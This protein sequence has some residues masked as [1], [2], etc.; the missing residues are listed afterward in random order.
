MRMLTCTC[1]LVV[2]LHLTSAL[3]A[4]APAGVQFDFGYLEP[5]AQLKV[6]CWADLLSAQLSSLTPNW[7][8]PQLVH[9]RAFSGNAIQHMMWAEQR[10]LDD[11]HEG[12]KALMQK[13]QQLVL[14][15]SDNTKQPRQQQHS[16]LTSFSNFWTVDSSSKPMLLNSF[17]RKLSM[18]LGSTSNLQQH[19]DQA[20]GSDSSFHP[21][22]SSIAG[23]WA[24]TA[25]PSHTNID[26]YQARIT[27]PG[28]T[29]IEGYLA[30]VAPP[31]H[32]SIEGYL[33]K[34]A[35]PSHTSINGYLRKLPDI[36]RQPSSGMP[37]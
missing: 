10:L 34:N 5:Q 35:P 28:H 15:S 11:M 7:Q 16:L 36:P 18:M 21:G 6:V 13:L 31:G 12:H 25:P 23:H 24:K 27:P 37:K 9:V 29:N 30:K 19:Q 14:P 20:P 2:W 1:I 26:G 17:S 3:R 4:A 32:T 33:A 22:H 8:L